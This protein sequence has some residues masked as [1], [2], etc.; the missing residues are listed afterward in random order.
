MRIRRDLSCSSQISHGLPTVS[1][2]A[3]STSFKTLWPAC[4]A[5]SS[6][7]R[8]IGVSS[9]DLTIMGKLGIPSKKIIL[10]LYAWHC[11]PTYNTWPMGELHILLMFVLD[12]PKAII[13]REPG[14]DILPAWLYYI[15]GLLDFHS[16]YKNIIC[17][18]FLTL[19][20]F[21]LQLMLNW[22]KWGSAYNAL[23]IS[24]N[25]LQ[26]LCQWFGQGILKGEVSLYCL[27]PVWLVW[28]SL[29]CK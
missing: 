19:F 14:W 13:M 26:S 25:K 2:I 12:G 3:S 22:C 28:I 16:T 8:W 9:V 5:T 4:A 1:E 20:A 17:R 27:P 6:N 7:D 24:M 23:T 11:T 29:F 18:S 21:G 15:L 10:A